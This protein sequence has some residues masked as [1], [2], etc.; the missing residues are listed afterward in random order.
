MFPDSHPVAAGISS[1]QP[2]K[3]KLIYSLLVDGWMNVSA[4]SILVHKASL[5]ENGFLIILWDG[6]PTVKQTGSCI[7]SVDLVKGAVSIRYVLWP[8]NSKGLKDS[9]FSFVH[10]FPK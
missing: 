9:R 5:I 10:A 1:L 8:N 2:S 3:D 6:T 4:F 7:I